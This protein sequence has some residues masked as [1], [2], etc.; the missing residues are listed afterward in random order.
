MRIMTILVGINIKDHIHVFI[1]KIRISLFIL[2]FQYLRYLQVK[3][4]YY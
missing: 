4:L 1:K 2:R 3:V